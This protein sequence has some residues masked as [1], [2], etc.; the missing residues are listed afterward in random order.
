MT[1]VIPPPLPTNTLYRPADEMLSL[2]IWTFRQTISKNFAENLELET[3][4]R[5][6]FKKL[7]TIVNV[8]YLDR[9]TFHD[10]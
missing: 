7:K 8:L 1:G 5:L 4:P 2:D 6:H 3:Q 9:F 10:P